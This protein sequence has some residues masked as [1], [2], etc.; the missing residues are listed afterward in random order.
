MN[1][2][3]SR[4]CLVIL[5]SVPLVVKGQDK[6]EYVNDNMQVTDSAHA[7]RY[8]FYTKDSSGYKVKLFRLNDDELLM[9]GYA[10][11]PDTAHFDGKFVFYK[12][13]FK[14]KE[15]NFENSRCTGQWTHYYDTSDKVWYTERY[16]YNHRIES[17]N[18]Y[19]K[20]GQQ[21]RKELFNT[22]GAAFGNCYDEQGKEIPFTPFVISPRLPAGFDFDKFLHK[23]LHYPY[24]AQQRKLMAKVIVEFTV[25]A[26]GD[27]TNVTV[28][29]FIGYGFD[30]EAIRV[31]KLMPKCEPARVD[32][33]PV[34]MQFGK[35]II[36]QLK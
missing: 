4:I 15:G 36:F 2:Y 12:D 13:G 23:N 26:T 34:T 22:A 16:S 24:D 27:I 32:D 7:T 6:T 35:T 20:N 10:T 11:A 14:S 9:K 5:L 25:A 19:Y 3:I 31:V 17:L 8:Y 28:S 29:K 30:D 1:T 33:Q 18:S 21:K